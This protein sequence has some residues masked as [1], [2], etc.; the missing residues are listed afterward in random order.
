MTLRKAIARRHGADPDRGLLLLGERDGFIPGV[1]ARHRGADDDHGPARFAQRG[2]RTRQQSGICRDVAAD[3]AR[4]KRR[5]GTIPVIHW[6]RDEGGTARRLHRDIV[7]SSD[8]RWNVRRARG[9]AAP[10]HIGFRQLRCLF[11]MEKGLERK[12][13]ARLLASGDH[14]RRLILVGGEDAAERVA[15]ADGGVQIDQSG[16]AAGLREAVGHGDHDR[17]LQAE[18]VAEVLWKVAEHGQLGRTRVAEDGR[19]PEFAQQ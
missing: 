14:E 6:N 2:C 15:D 18:H 4:R 8:R 13:G 11:G 12:Y 7:G 1:I 3:F 17:F 5:T 10:F 9:F 19:N 16:L